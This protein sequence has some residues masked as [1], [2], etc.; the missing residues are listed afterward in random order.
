M[1]DQNQLK[2]LLRYDPDTGVFTWLKSYNNVVTGKPAKT[3]GR[4]GYIDIKIKGIRH[5]AHRLAWLYMTGK[6]P[7]NVIDH[8]DRD[9]TNNSFSNLRD[10][11][12][13]ENTNN[14]VRPQA[15]NKTGVRG[16]IPY[17]NGYSS[18]ISVNGKNIHLGVFRS[19]KDAEGAYLSAKE[20][21][22]PLPRKRP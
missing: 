18:Q 22:A 21:Y 17:V 15:N 13:K 12:S 10:V 20:I 14:Q 3:K 4:N 16:V 5:Y 19:I 7:N 9:K 2:E 6:N 8:I 1:I 11:S